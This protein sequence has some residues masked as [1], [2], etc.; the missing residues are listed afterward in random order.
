M[1]IAGL[2]GRSMWVIAALIGL[3]SQ[4]RPHLLPRHTVLV[5]VVIAVILAGAGQTWS[6]PAFFSWIADLVPQ[7]VRPTFFARRTLVGTWISLTTGLASGWL[8]DRYPQQWIYCVI[9][10]AA[11]IAGL[12]EMLCFIRVKEPPPAMDSGEGLPPLLDSL[13]VPL[14]DPA[15]QIFLLFWAVIMFS[16]GFFGPFTWLHALERLEFSQTQANIALVV[17]PVIGVG[18]TTRFWAAVIK[19]H[20]NR[21]MVRLGSIAYAFVP[22]TWLLARHTSHG[23]WVSW[24]FVFIMTTLVSAIASGVDIANQNMVTGLSPH[25]PRSTMTALFFIACGLSTALGTWSGGALA[26]WLGDKPYYPLGI[27]VTNYNVL[28]LG[29]LML[30]LIAAAFIAPQLK[31]PAASRTR[32]MVSDIVPEFAHSFAARIVR[33]FRFRD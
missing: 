6:Y 17:G 29:A 11:G 18:C 32:E 12:V 4:L 23:P 20:G 10:G 9:L 2:T 13:V 27:P 7:R 19:R 15:I 33:S 5:L 30:R 8:A 3:M 22:A 21:P 14:R 25:V 28:F 24:G 1:M 31:E 26:E 16:V